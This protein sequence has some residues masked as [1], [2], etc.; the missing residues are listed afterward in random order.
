MVN[1]YELSHTIPTLSRSSEISVGWLIM[2][3]SLLSVGSLPPVN[4]PVQSSQLQESA[5]HSG[6]AVANKHGRPTF[7]VCGV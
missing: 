3:I 7:A 5:I 6:T 1:S 2:F 4:N